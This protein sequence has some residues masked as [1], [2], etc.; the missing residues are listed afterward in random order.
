MR[1]SLSLLYESFW[2]LLRSLGS[3]DSPS[4]TLIS[5]SLFCNISLNDFPTYLNSPLILSASLVTSVGHYIDYDGSCSQRG[6]IY[7][8]EKE[9]FGSSY[10]FW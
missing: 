6:L 5:L 7:E 1:F 2:E 10:D 9:D 8:F 4:L 3:D